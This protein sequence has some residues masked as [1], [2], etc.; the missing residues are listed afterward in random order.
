MGLIKASVLAGAGLYAYKKFSKRHDETK[1]QS[2]QNQPQNPYYNN[3][4]NPSARDVSNTDGYPLR[5]MSEKYHYQPQPAYGERDSYYQSQQQ[6]QRLP[7]EK[8]M[9]LNFQAPTRDYKI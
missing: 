2:S 4:S 5:P 3:S 9:Q 8:P 1:V 6:P 7:H